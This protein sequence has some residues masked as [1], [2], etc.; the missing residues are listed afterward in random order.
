MYAF[1]GNRGL[2]ELIAEAVGRLKGIPLAAGTGR[3]YGELL[4]MLTLK[5]LGCLWACL[6]RCCL[7]CGSGGDSLERALV[8][9]TS[10]PI[11]LKRDRSP[12]WNQTV[13]A[14]WLQG[15]RT[16]RSDDLSGV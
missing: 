10:V 13:S 5:D 3:S 12:P 11:R 16:G 4:D 8:S 2:G 15:D 6:S 14:L 1:S 7:F 9:A